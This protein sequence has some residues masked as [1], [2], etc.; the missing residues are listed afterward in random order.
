MKTCPSCGALIG[1]H[2]AVCLNCEYVFSSAGAES[3]R[4]QSGNNEWREESREQKRQQESQNLLK[5]LL[6]NSNKKPIIQYIIYKSFYSE[7]ITN[8]KI[9]Y[10]YLH[11][12]FFV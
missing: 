8:K 6:D 4:K 7:D 11:H 3:D 5:N 2:E 10:N 1:E 9:Y 12:S